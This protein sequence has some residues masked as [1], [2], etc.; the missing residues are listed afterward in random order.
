MVILFYISVLLQTLK[1]GF[2][3]TKYDPASFNSIWVLARS[4]GLVVL[5]VVSN[6]MVCTLL[7]GRGKLR[8]ITVVS[9]YSLLPLVIKNF[10][11]V[12]L[13][14]VLL[15]SETSFLTILDAVALIYFVL[16]MICGLL[17]IHDFSFGRLVLTSVLSL[18]GV[19]IIFF[20]MIMI[21]MLFQQTAGFIAT[22]VSE[23][24]M[25]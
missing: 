23:L 6:W 13:S 18:L 1:G 4:V 20:L 22:V 9:C 10:I 7:G 17:K 19:A 2:L 24:L 25:L 15:P 14:N 21:V 5:W 3:F 8:E 11:T 16:L 12:I